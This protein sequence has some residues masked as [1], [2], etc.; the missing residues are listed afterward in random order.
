MD[1]QP[2]H[3]DL[4]F[5]ILHLPL[6][7]LNEKTIAE[8]GVNPVY[9]KSDIEANYQA[10]GVGHPCGDDLTISLRTHNDIITDLRH[11]GHS[12]C[13]TTAFADILCHNLI[14]QK[15]DQL[16]TVSD[17]VD[18]AVAKNREGCLRLPV[19]LLKELYGQTQT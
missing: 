8:F 6:L 2:K 10:S 16:I 19:K 14:G 12:C 1:K 18:I 9:K 17:I 11:S 3:S 4:S 7:K 13:L 5:A 15:V